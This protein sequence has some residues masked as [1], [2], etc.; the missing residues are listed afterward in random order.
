VPPFNDTRAREA[1][2]VDPS[3]DVVL[4]SADELSKVASTIVEIPLATDIVNV[5]KY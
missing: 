3:A 5:V 1:E 2:P 4:C